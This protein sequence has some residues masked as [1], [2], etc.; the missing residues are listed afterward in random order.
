MQTQKMLTFLSFRILED[1][2]GIFIGEKGKGMIY[3][4]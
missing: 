1:Y 4:M 3:K 2:N